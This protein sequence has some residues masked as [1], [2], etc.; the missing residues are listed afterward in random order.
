MSKKYYAVKNGYTTG[1]FETW[2]ECEK[3]VKGFSGAEYK[4]FKTK[5]EAK[6]YL[7]MNPIDNLVKD[8]KRCVAYIDGSFNKVKQLCGYGVVILDD[9]GNEIEQFYGY[10]NDEA[11]L[12]SWNISGEVE[13]AKKAITFALKNNY[14]E[15]DIYYDYIGIE[16]WGNQEWK[17]N[18]PLTISYKQ[19]I[20][21]SRNR[22][23]INF[24]KVK[25]H[26]G[27]KYNELADELAKNGAQI[28]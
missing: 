21:N 20:K 19:F 15:I 16:K 24:H 5:E 25:A 27:N 17:T 6:S 10:I 1:I 12:S 14:E 8:A 28:N 9:K 3:Q 22:I 23:K 11:S 2:T 4:S 13:S 26:S 7:E 18:I